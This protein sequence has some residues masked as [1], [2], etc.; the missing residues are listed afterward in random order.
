MGYPSPGLLA[1]ATLSRRER[2]LRQ[3]IFEFVQRIPLP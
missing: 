1:Q 2:D 3:N